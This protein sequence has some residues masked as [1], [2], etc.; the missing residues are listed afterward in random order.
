MLVAYMY[1]RGLQ[2]HLAGG[3]KHRK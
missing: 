2:L 1:A 3:Q